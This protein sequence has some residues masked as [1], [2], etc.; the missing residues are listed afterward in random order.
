MKFKI[1]MRCLSDG[2]GYTKYALIVLYNDIFDTEF[3]LIYN[4][5]DF[6]KFEIIDVKQFVTTIKNMDIYDGDKVLVRG[7]KRFGDYETTVLKVLQGWTLDINETYLNDD[8][9][10]MAIISKI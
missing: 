7:T 5:T 1:T 4:H 9:C 3:G 8:A 2:N 10:L 6:K